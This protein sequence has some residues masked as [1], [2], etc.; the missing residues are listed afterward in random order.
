M[1]GASASALGEN[2]SVV[3][4]KKGVDVDMNGLNCDILVVAPELFNANQLPGGWFLTPKDAYRDTEE[5]A[6]EKDRLRLEVQQ[7][8]IEDSFKDAS[9]VEEVKEK[10]EVVTDA[11]KALIGNAKIRNDAKEAG[12]EDWKKARIETLKDKLKA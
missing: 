12:I 11:P 6:A 8:E 1:V 5:E 3:L 2:M 9:N 4:Y 10:V 7:K